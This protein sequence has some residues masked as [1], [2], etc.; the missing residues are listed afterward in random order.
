MVA[1]VTIEFND[2]VGMQSE[3]NFSLCT[4]CAHGA[5]G[6]FGAQ[7]VLKAA[8]LTTNCWSQAP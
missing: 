6:T 3:Q 8:P 2:S 1:R 5:S 4:F 7:G